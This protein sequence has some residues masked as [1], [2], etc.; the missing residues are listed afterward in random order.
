M[1]SHLSFC[2][3][4]LSCA[5]GAVWTQVGSRVSPGELKDYRGRQVTVCG[6]VAT[7]DCNWNR[8]RATIL[9]LDKP[10]WSN[11]EAVLI[12]AL[13]RPG[14]PRDLESRYTLGTICAT[15]LVERRD[16]RDVVRV[17]EPAHIT[18]E[19]EAP[20]S[21]FPPGAMRP[22][23]VGVTMP[24]V[25]RDAKPSYT[26]E[27]MRA[28][29][30]GIVFMEALITPGGAVEMARVLDGPVPKLGLD[31]EAEKA[32]R[33]WRFRSGTFEGRPVAV[34]VTIELQFTLK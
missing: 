16:N 8:D 12:P 21:L 33:Q 22:C 32:V 10:H 30:Q 15:G 26:M 31:E 6:R 5:I 9:H 28:A 3:A 34:I 2:A 1:S 14:F 27:A 20:A 11:R 19:K 13:A 29:Q 23:D 17:E 24:T 4:L 7:H 18:V 25:V